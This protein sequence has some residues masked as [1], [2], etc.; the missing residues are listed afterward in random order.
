MV[1]NVVDVS[2]HQTVQQ[3][4]TPGADACIVKVTQGNYYVNPKCDQQYQL[5]KKNGLKLGVYHYAGGKD[6][7]TEA[8]YFLEHAKG[9][10][11]EAILILDWEAADNANYNDTNWC[12]R[13]V[14]YVYQQT[15][16]WC[17]LYGNAQDISRATNLVNDCGLW[18]AGYPTNTQRNWN[19]PEFIYNI[20]PW[21]SM[22]GWQYSAA[23]VDRSKFYITKEQWDAYASKEGINS[24][25]T[26]KDETKNIN[27]GEFG[28]FI[29]YKKVGNGVLQ[30]GVWGNKRFHL[31]NQDK[32]THFS[33]I[34]KDFTG[35]SVKVYS[36]WTEN[37]EQIRTVESFTE[38][39]S[40]ITK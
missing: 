18:F 40:T 26:T 22:I 20:S 39:Q 19:A 28:M 16:V 3:A 34:V 35:K 14:D 6:A 27:L 9:Y 31:N 36:S 2:S 13:F 30:M 32:V 24:T 23:D 11:G 33:N 29:Y 10:I 17:V 1:L 5:A 15:G 12:R 38:L 7:I 37:S 8:K 21:K 25:A 4:V